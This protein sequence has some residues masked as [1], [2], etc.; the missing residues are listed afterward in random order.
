MLEPRIA[1][2]HQRQIHREVRPAFGGGR[3]AQLLRRHDDPLPHLAVAGQVL[4]DR[5]RVVVVG[6]AANDVARFVEA[7]DVVGEKIPGPVE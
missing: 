1:V 2:L 3:E 7:L 4:L 6:V 5:L